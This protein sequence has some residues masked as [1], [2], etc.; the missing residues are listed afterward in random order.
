MENGKG[1]YTERKIYEENQ[2]YIQKKK[3][4]YTQRRTE[5]HMKMVDDSRREYAKKNTHV[6]KSNC[7][8]QFFIKRIPELAMISEVY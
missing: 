5:D 2:G 6:S 1:T 7:N 3:R 8:S 4:K